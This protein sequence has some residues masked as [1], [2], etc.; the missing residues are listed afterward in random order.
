[1]RKSLT[2]L[3]RHSMFLTMRMSEHPG[4]ACGWPLAAAAAAVV[5]V[6][7]AREAVAVTRRAPIQH[8]HS[9]ATSTRRVTRSNPRGNTLRRVDA[10]TFRNSC[11]AYPRR[12]PAQRRQIAKAARRCETQVLATVVNPI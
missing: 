3:W 2:S 9:L 7:A 8:R 5:A 11:L 1:M 6:V 12:G 4:E 10:A